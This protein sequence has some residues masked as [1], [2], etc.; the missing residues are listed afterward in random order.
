MSDLTVHPAAGT[1]GFGTLPE[2]TAAVVIGCGLTGLAVASELSRRGI[3][4]IVL[5]GLRQ[6]SDSVHC[7]APDPRSLPE[8]ADLLR[9][10]RGYA[11]GHSL[12]IR[13]G[14]PA[15]GLGQLRGSGDPAR[16]GRSAEPG[17]IV[18]GFMT[19]A[20]RTR[21]GVLLADAVVLAGCGQA[22]L[23]QLIRALGFAAGP[24][25]RNA[26]RGVGLYIVGSGEAPAVPTRELV[27][28]AKRAGQ[29]VADRNAAL[30]GASAL[31]FRTA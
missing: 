25:L 20:V 5:N 28:Q 17:I 27:R 11:A 4:P 30:A 23:V 14:T 15:E 26:L 2:A 12:D 1:A 7:P 29:E 3:D 8:R 31:R 9:L 19:W 6:D 13:R 10:L 18:P 21:N 22:A 16:T 24:E